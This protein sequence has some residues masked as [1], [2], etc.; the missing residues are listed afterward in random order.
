MVIKNLP[1]FL[2]KN[3]FQGENYTAGQ[4]LKKLLISA[5]QTS[6]LTR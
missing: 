1:K 4:Q 5:L 6:F 3:I 2:P